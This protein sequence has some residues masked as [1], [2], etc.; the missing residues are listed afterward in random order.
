[1]DY[2]L[3]L[4]PAPQRPFNVNRFHGSW[5]WF[6]DY[7]TGDLGNDG[8]HRIDYARRALSAAMEAQSG[9]LPDWPLA[10][11]AAGGK[12]V[13]DDA[14]EW[15]DTLMVTWEYPG[16][17]LNYE[18]RVWCGYPMETEEEGAAVYGTDGYVVIGNGSWRAF[19]PKGEPTSHGTASTNAEHDAAHQ[20]NFIECVRSGKLPNFDIAEG[21]VSSGLCHLGNTAWRVGRKLKFDPATMRYADDPEA[22]RHL[23]RAYRE[24]WSLPMNR[25]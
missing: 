3:W 6:F 11:S 12:F 1:V 7:G 2:D 23:S 14:Q 8:V 4:G 21:H 13:F 5:R 22:C 15:P 10:V 17:I 9:K 19:G 25:A 16:A 24:P 20:Q 18:M